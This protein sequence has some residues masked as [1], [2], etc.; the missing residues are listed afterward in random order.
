MWF[1][2]NDGSVVDQAG[3]VIFFSTN[4][5]VRDICLG[6]CCFICGAQRGT[7]EFNDE[8]ILP[9]WLLRRYDLFSRKITLP[10]EGTVRYDRY[11][12]PCCVDCNSLMGRVVEKPVSDVVQ[13]G[14]D[15]INALVTSGDLLKIFVWMG[16]IFLKTHLKDR[17]HRV[18]MDTRK[19]DHKIA[20]EYDWANLHHIHSVVR[21]FYTN[22]F[23][24]REAIG[25]FLSI[26]VK[27][28]LPTER[29]DYSDLYLAQSMLLR[30]DD[31]ALLVVFNDSGGAMN[32]FSQKLKRIAGPVSEIQLR[33]ILAELAFLNLHIKERPVFRT[34]C[35]LL[36]ESCRVLARRPTL[37]LEKL[38]WSVRGELLAH[39]LRE[40]LPNITLIGRS[41][42]ELSDALE[43]G[44]LSFLFDD[45]GE[46]IGTP[47]KLLPPAS[48]TRD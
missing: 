13:R 46:F 30:L 44:R 17:A 36:N 16:L 48:E 42:R 19:G 23:V 31:T 1:V 14:G 43:V 7:R 3:K 21:C 24:E 39:A 27:A 5:F 29:F 26:P 38:D 33:E 32:Y 4:R 10:N 11:T 35:D 18:H 22:C 41:Q 34:D 9:E 12:I 37:E 45:D 40:I 2:E 15:A 47:W 6:E 25:S 20:D 28:Q 8:H